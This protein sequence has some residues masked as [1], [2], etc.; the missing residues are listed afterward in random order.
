MGVS[1]ESYIEDLFKYFNLYE[2][3]YSDFQSEAF[4][5][6]YNG[7]YAVFQALQQQRDKAVDVDQYFLEKL[8]QTPLTSSDLRQLSI[9]ILITFFESEADTDGQSNRAYLYCRELR[10]AKRDTTF[11]EESLIP[12]L[13]AEGSLNENQELRSF[14][15]SEIGRYI[16]TFG[17][18]VQA[19]LSPEAFAAMSDPLKI[20]ELSRRRLA[21][22]K[23]LLKD[24]NSLEFHLQ[25]VGALEKL[26]D[27]SNTCDYFLNRWNYLI[28]TSFWAS[29]KRT[30]SAVWGKFKGLF[31]SFRFFRL[32]LS[33][34][35]PAYLFYSM[36]IILFILLAIYVPMKWQSYAND[37]LD[38]FNERAIQTQNDISK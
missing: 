6:T 24:R 17:K 14:F 36:I 26:S 21:L 12:L 10:A 5:Q 16:N 35:N 8:K 15:L 20:L 28:K 37:K 18:S 38:D 32:A 30:L 22:G 34:R 31:S 9:Q 23:E 25:R 13:M 19:D 33:Q 3:K 27:K 29:V 4:F 1:I 2:T 7:I 11:F